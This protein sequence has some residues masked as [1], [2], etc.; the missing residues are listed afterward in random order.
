MSWLERPE[1]YGC[2][3]HSYEALLVNHIES[4]LRSISKMIGA[5]LQIV[6]CSLRANYRGGS[7]DDLQ[8]NENRLLICL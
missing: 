5:I 4:S 1:V 3:A 2:D 8:N 6:Q 7:L